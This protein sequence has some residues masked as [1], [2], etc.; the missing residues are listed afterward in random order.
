M[1]ISEHREIRT[2]NA[3]SAVR[4][5]LFE[6]QADAVRSK[7]KL[8]QLRRCVSGILTNVEAS[9]EAMGDLATSELRLLDDRVLG[10]TMQS[11]GGLLEIIRTAAR[12]D[13]P[14]DDSSDRRLVVSN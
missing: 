11:L 13:S 14:Q 6:A 7:E 10:A 2:P 8:T 3:L 9:P 1:N 12:V 5:Q 4:R